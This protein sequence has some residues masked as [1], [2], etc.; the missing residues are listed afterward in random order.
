MYM[1]LGWSALEWI[2]HVSDQPVAPSLGSTVSTGAPLP[3]ASC[4]MTSH[5]VPSTDEPCSNACCS[6]AYWFQYSPTTFRCSFNNAT[7]A[8]NCSWLN[9]YGSSMPR[10]GWAD[11]RY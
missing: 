3:W 5:V 9:E 8:S 4:L 1:Q 10:S 7:A 2:I 11:F 6:T